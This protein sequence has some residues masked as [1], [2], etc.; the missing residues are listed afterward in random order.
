MSNFSQ[1]HNV[2][3]FIAGKSEALTGQRLAKVGYK[4]TAKTPAKYPSVCVSVP[5]LTKESISENISS[6]LGHI[7]AML[8]TAQDGIIRSLYESSD[9]A[10][11]SVTDSDISV[12]AC[13]AFLDA[14]SQGSRL[15]KEFVA[16]WFDGAVKESLYVVF[17]EKL[18]FISATD[19]N[20]EVTE[21]QD[22]VIN[23][24][25]AGY[26]DLFSSLAGGKNI[27][28]EKQID[29]LVKA[30][31][32]SGAED[33]TAQKLRNRL[34]QMRSKP[35]KMEEL[36]ELVNLRSASIEGPT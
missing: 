25:I 13:I 16:G 29:G 21:D 36:V 4:S 27:L 32:I 22:K 20:P 23:K 28:Q 34:E 12:Q 18:G 33:E 24:H 6:M 17:A 1:A 19:D 15:T 30:L 2:T 26:R 3:K 31:D 8:E 7:R 10:L 9:G 11:S 35:Q 5:V 14:E